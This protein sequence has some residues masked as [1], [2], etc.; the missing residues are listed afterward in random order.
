VPVDSGAGDTE[1]GG[2]LRHGVAA[3]AVWAG[4]V[5]HLLGDA[6]WRGVSL[7]FC[8]PVRPRVRAAA[9]PSMVRSDISA[10]SNSA[11][12]PRIWKNI[13]PTAVEVS[14]PWSSTTR[15][16]PRSWRSRTG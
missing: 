9:R 8:P 5:I 14:I 15:S 3:L 13:R 2:D 6:A 10:C 7:G 11:I 12:A 1:L 16:T 4:L